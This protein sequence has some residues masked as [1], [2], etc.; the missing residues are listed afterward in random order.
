MYWIVGM[1]FNSI[2]GAHD[3]QWPV[4]TQLP[5]HSQSYL[6]C[7]H[8]PTGQ[9]SPALNHTIYLSWSS[10]QHVDAASVLWVTC[11]T[12]IL[13]HTLLVL[14]LMNRIW[15][16]QTTRKDLFSLPMSSTP[17]QAV[18][19][20]ATRMVN[21]QIFWM[22]MMMKVCLFVVALFLEPFIDANI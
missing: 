14:K 1:L 4:C 3:T 17:L 12:S 18:M 5:A 6:T 13:H 8:L 2:H 7:S 21:T 15:N 20:M 10:A 16:W 11:N 22:S 19:G 9:L